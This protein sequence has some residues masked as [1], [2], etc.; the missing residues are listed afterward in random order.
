MS[1]YVNVISNQILIIVSTFV[2]QLEQLRAYF[3]G[4]VLKL[5]MGTF[6]DEPDD[7]NK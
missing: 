7:I 2:K 1:E 4:L 5:N 6:S 3:T